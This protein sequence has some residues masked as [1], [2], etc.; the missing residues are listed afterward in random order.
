MIA[1]AKPGM[2]ILNLYVENLMRVRAVDITPQGNLVILAGANEQ[3]K[4]AVLNAI[5][6]AL[7]GKSNVTSR[8]IRDGEEEA[9]IKLDLGEIVVTRTFKRDPDNGD[10]TTKLNVVGRE[11]EKIEAAQTMVLN[12]LLGALAMDPID[13]LRMDAKAQLTALRQF[14]PAEFDLEGLEKRIDET[15]R[16]REAVGRDHRALE[17][18]ADGV[19]IQPDWSPD[20]IKLETFFAQVHAADEHNRNVEHEESRRSGL[21]SRA[22]LHDEAALDKEFRAAKLRKEAEDLDAEAHGNRVAAKQLREEHAALPSMPVVRDVSDITAEIGR[23]EQHNKNAAKVI[24]KRDLQAKA[25]ARGNDYKGLTDDIESMRGRRRNAIA[26]AIALIGVE[27]LG[28]DDLKDEVTFNGLPLKQASTAQQIRVALGIAAAQSPDLR[29]ILIREGSLL[30]SKS[31]ALVEEFAT[32]RD[33][34]VWMERVDESGK[35]GFNMVDGMVA[36]AREMAVAS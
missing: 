9:I 35:L 34:Q 20:I 3:G 11:G 33:L 29:V 28:F 15:Y 2:R 24:Q 30:D 19:A 31:M 6:W 12:K 21:L 4:S 5:W 17:A 36:N 7:A 13:F 10:I 22:R 23:A 8:P 16:V 26:K 27:G 18:Q 25:E 1:P 14:V 32:E